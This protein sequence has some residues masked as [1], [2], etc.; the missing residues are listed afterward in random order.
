M[1][2]K[3]KVL[4]VL[5]LST[6]FLALL[7]MVAVWFQ[8]NQIKQFAVSKLNE[9]LSAPVSVQTIDISFFDQF[10]KVS[11][12][13]N[14]VSIKDPMRPKY[15][16]FRAQKVFVA[17]NI[18]DI[19]SKNYHVKLIEA[20]SGV[21]NIYV[22]RSGKA[23]YDIFKHTD[24]GNDELLL[25]LSE[26]KIKQM[27][28][29]FQNLESEFE[30]LAE[31]NEAVF[32]GDF[33]GKKESLSLEGD[34]LFQKLVSGST[35]LIKDKSVKLEGNM[36]IDEAKQLYTFSKTSLKVGAL[37]LDCSGS[38]E[39]REQFKQF[40]IRFD[41][42]GMRITDLLELLPGTISR[43]VAEYKSTGSIYFNGSITGKLSAKQS[44]N[45]KVQFGIE[46][47]T[48]TA[49]GGTV[50]LKQIQCKGEFSNG[51]SGRLKDAYL[52]L[53]VMSFQ[54]GGGN[55][56]GAVNIKNFDN[57]QLSL[58]LKGQ[59]P[60][61]DLLTFTRTQW[62]QRAEGQLKV[63]I[64]LN[65]SLKQ[66]SSQAG[67][68]ECQTSGSVECNAAH[69]LLTEGNKTIDK[70]DAVLHVRQKDLVIET[71]TAKV[72]QSDIR[73]TGAFK[74][75]V[76]FL[77]S[78]KQQLEADID[79]HS[80]KLDIENFIFPSTASAS[81]AAPMRLP[82]N[83]FVNAQVDIGEL[84]F[85][86]FKA[87]NVKGGIFW[88]GK[89]I[90]AES[91]SAETFNGNILVNG[92]I[93]NAANGNFL[94][95]AGVQFA[96]V[97]IDELF[98]QCNNFGQLEITHKHIK[99]KMQGMIEIAGVWNAKLDCD[100]NKLS[101]LSTINIK[102]GELNNYQPLEG[103]SKYVKVEDLRKL[104]FADLSNQIAIRKGVITIPE[105]VV[106][107]NALNLTV[108]GTH[109]FNNYLDYHFKLKLNDLLAKKYKQR[110]NEFEEEAVERGTF[111]FIS[112]KGPIDK[113]EFSYD[114]KQAKAQVKQDIKKEREEVKKLWRKELG[115]DKDETIKEQ[116]TESDELEFE[117][118]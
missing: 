84:V 58:A 38:I 45:M 16:L 57:P 100:L 35:T 88:K 56:A 39:H 60:I 17:F 105:M 102:Q 74:N 33:K 36:R 55:F 110:N 75:L 19:L 47:G 69:I 3:F 8:R 42:P 4:L 96:Q 40:D 46:N 22:D 43:Q 77:L 21:C 90:T 52:I 2:K 99:G 78:E 64:S 98:R 81:T 14:Q 13:F 25:K 32:S 85:Y 104:K 54:L 71:L 103:L 18:L 67:F 70:L 24:A 82:S 9:Q 97:D 93:E 30:L 41:A 27:K 50:S 112:M 80:T 10:P 115:L 1:K 83:I 31:A 49:E 51:I 73:V 92:Q 89:R 91:L 66:L 44:P 11:L 111:L 101:V 87:R 59:A 28:V 94:V 48:V 34:F 79:Y 63:D 6:L 95:S 68:L 117:A 29:R 86:E 26:V 62:V 113:L 72:N 23:N 53:P 76:P 107:N 5:F 15:V 7:L 65:G 108:S 61:Q 109:T 106:N 114:K 20:D 37:A 118:E 12:R 116:N